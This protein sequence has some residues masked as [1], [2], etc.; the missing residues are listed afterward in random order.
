MQ[1]R[2]TPDDIGR[3]DKLP[4]FAAALDP[5]YLHLSFLTV[6]QRS[7]AIAVLKEKCKEI[8]QKKADTHIEENNEA[9]DQTDHE[10]PS[11]KKEETTL[12]FLLG[13]DENH[14]EDYW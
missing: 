4:I 8:F 11:K 1:H 9:S 5:R 2:F 3:A 10:P 13:K 12:S 14:N 7:I 6:R